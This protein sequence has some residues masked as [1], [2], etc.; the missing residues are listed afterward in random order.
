MTGLWASCATETFS[1][2]CKIS[3]SKVRGRCLTET[4]WTKSFSYREMLM[5]AEWQSGLMAFLA[6]LSHLKCRVDN[7]ITLLMNSERESIDSVLLPRNCYVYLWPCPY[8]T[9]SQEPVREHRNTQET[10]LIMWPSSLKTW[11]KLQ[12]RLIYFLIAMIHDPILVCYIFF[13]I[14]YYFTVLYA[15][16]FILSAY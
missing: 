9:A 10:H 5:A 3:L 6:E 7:C 16:L 2:R 11:R 1:E 12:V 8:Q 15:H 13:P 14:Y 4:A